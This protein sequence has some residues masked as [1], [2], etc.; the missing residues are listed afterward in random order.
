MASACPKCG[1][2]ISMHCETCGHYEVTL[3]KRAERDPEALKGLDY[4]F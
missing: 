1:N 4:H 3:L 2:P